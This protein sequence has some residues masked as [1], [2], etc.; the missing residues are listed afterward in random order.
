MGASDDG[1]AWRNETLDKENKNAEA[2]SFDLDVSGGAE[3]LQLLTTFLL[4]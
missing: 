1:V 4:R 2:S 3:L